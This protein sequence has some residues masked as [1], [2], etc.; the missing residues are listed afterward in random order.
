MKKLTPIS[1]VALILLIVGGLNWGLVG[2]FNF[3]LVK[4]LF[5]DTL[6]VPVLA[7]IVYIIVGVC[8]VIVLM[9]MCCCCKKTDVCETPKEQPPQSE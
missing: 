6:N 9:G 5:A 4:W 8:A 7:K 3:D 1:C 2:L